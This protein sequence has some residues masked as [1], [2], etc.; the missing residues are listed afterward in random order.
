MSNI[1]LKLEKTSARPIRDNELKDLAEAFYK[2]LTATGCQ[3]KQTLAVAT[4]MIK[5]VTDSLATPS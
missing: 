3:G 4:H 5:L 2:R 1:L